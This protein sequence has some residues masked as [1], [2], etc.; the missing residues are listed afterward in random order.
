MQAKKIKRAFLVY[1]AGIANV[2]AVEA[3]NLADYGRE[4]RRLYQGDFHSAA[5]LAR[6]LEAAG[7]VV[8]TA[9]CNRAGDIRTETWTDDLDSQPF[10]EQFVVFGELVHPK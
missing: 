5:M 4:A 3:F 9:A 6:G 7:V 8:K 1:Q 2:F 10:S